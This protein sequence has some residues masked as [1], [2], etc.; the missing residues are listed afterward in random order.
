LS[1]SNRGFIVPFHLTLLFVPAVPVQSQIF[2]TRLNDSAGKRIALLCVDSPLLCILSCPLLCLQIHH[3]L[4]TGERSNPHSGAIRVPQSILQGLYDM[5]F[6][7]P[8]TGTIPGHREQR[9]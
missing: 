4:T 5:S 8:W 9:L 2:L 3:E 7:L 1:N 6:Y